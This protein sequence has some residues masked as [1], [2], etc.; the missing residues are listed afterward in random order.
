M[1]CF[2]NAK[3]NI[4]LKILEKTSDGFH[5][6]ESVFYPIGLSDILEL[7]EV[8]N[9]KTETEITFNSTG[10]KIPGETNSNLCVRAYHL[11]K[12]DYS[13]PAIKVHLHKIIPIGAGLGGGSSD[14]AFFIKLLNDAFEIGISWGE[15]HNYA[16]QLGSDCSFFI[17]NKSSFAEGRGDRYEYIP[18]DLSSYFLVLVS[19]PIHIATAEAYARVI[20][21]VAT[22]SLEDDIINESIASWKNTISND[23]EISVFEKYPRIK[24]IKEIIYSQGAIYASMTGSGSSVYGIFK[25]QADVQKKFQDCFVWQGQLK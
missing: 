4:G 9:S 3:I 23:F 21:K 16:R 14:A 13:L 7:V 22:T 15:M 6:I 12:N 1:I 11:I 8:K 24:E 20:P 5:N 10:I 17:S 2:P 19:P 25:H 18:L